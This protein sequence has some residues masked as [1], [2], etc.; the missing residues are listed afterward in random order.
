MLVYLYTME[1]PVRIY[2][3]LTLVFNS[4]A[5]SDAEL[6]PVLPFMRLLAAKLPSLPKALHVAETAT[7]F[8]GVR[9]DSAASSRAWEWQ[10][11]WHTSEDDRILGE[12][13]DIFFV[14]SSHT[15]LVESIG[16]GGCRWNI[17]QAGGA[18]LQRG[19]KTRAATTRRAPLRCAKRLG[20]LCGGEVCNI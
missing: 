19:A 2:A 4:R 18:G 17:L 11:I 10:N 20:R 8:R 12:K 9:C 13:W 7:L 14:S 16:A 6:K 15:F 5:R 1:R 3:L